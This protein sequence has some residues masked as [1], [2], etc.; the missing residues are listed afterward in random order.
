MRLLLILLTL[1]L[2]SCEQ[3]TED[4]T[5]PCKGDCVIS[6]KGLA[7]I[8]NFEG[9]SEYKYKDSAGYWTI[10]WGHLIKEGEEFREPMDYKTAETV[11]KEDVKVAEKI[12]NKKVKVALTQ[13]Q[14][15]AL[16]SF[17][18]N[19]GSGN[20]SKS[21]LLIKLNSGQNKVP[22]ELQRWVYAGGEKLTGLVLRRKAEG[23]LYRS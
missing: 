23:L 1:C 4:D 11:L 13:E 10:A 7:L 6:N 14:F 15:D 22:E 5:T 21:T 2:F 12:V 20:F 9:F 17:A 16:V 8:R 3:K 18:F 19:V